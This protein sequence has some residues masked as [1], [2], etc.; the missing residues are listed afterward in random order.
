M[1]IGNSGKNEK[2][3]KTKKTTEFFLKKVVTKRKWKKQHG[4]M[5]TEIHLENSKH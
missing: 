5:E 2:M 3:Q 1:K 4:N